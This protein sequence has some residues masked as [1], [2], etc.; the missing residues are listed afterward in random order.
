MGSQSVQSISTCFTIAFVLSIS[1]PAK[2][3]PCSID[4]TL[5]LLFFCHFSVAFYYLQL[6]PILQKKY[7]ERR[8]HT[9]WH[10]DAIAMIMVMGMTSH[11]MTYLCSPATAEI[12]KI[13][14]T[15]QKQNAIIYFT[16]QFPINIIITGQKI[17]T[18]W[19]AVEHWT[20]S[21]HKKEY[22][23]I[24]LTAKSTPENLPAEARVMR[25]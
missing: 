23:V 22:L 12:N 1:P 25:E 4:S 24:K 20:R 5:H 21:N 7:A 9:T 3:L 17:I 6:P 8:Q 18:D 15:V 14:L 2:N 10:P 19:Y 13:Y 16:T 11:C